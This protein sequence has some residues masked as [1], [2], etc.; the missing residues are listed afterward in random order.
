MTPIDNLEERL[1]KLD[2]SFKAA[3]TDGYFNE[4]P[5]PGSY[6][7]IFRSVEFF[8]G[9]T[10]GEAFIKLVFEVVLDKVYAGREIGLIHSLEPQGTRDF[11]EMKYSFLKR[12]L[13]TLGVPVDEEDF[14]L[15]QVRPGSTI[16]EPV[17]DVPVEITVKE[18]KKLNPNTGKPYIN[19]FLDARLGAPLP[20]GQLPGSDIPATDD[21]QPVP[22]TDLDDVPF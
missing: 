9:K 15:A 13:K 6:Q 3:P 16:W 22:S 2:E 14:S 7:A 11:V 10:N 8:E 21:P 17:L 12:D 19:A 18:S 1:A 5:E 20:Q 4:L